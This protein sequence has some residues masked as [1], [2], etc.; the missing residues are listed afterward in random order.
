MS[1]RAVTTPFSCSSADAGVEEFVCLSA[2]PVLLRTTGGADESLALSVVVVAA[3]RSRL[4][5]R[6]RSLP[7]RATK[8]AVA[9]LSF[10]VP[11]VAALLVLPVEVAPASDL[12]LEASGDPFASASP[13]RALQGKGKAVYVL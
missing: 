12:T 9:G 4:R 13:A 8:E 10:A 7:E 6:K 2:S 11:E 5:V 3:R 1:F